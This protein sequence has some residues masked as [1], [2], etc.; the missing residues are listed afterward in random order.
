MRSEATLREVPVSGTGSP[1]RADEAGLFPKMTSVPHLFPEHENPHECSLLKEFR[2]VPTSMSGDS[3]SGRFRP[4]EGG[5]CVYDPWEQVAQDACVHRAEPSE[6]IVAVEQI[7][8]TPVEIR[9]G[10]GAFVAVPVDRA[11]RRSPTWTALRAGPQGRVGRTEAEAMLLLACAAG[12][13]AG[14]TRQQAAQ[15][16]A[17]AW[18]QEALGRAG[19]AVLIF[20][21]TEIAKCAQVS[22]T[23]L[24]RAA[25]RLGID[26]ATAGMNG[27]WVWA[28][29][30]AAAAT[31]APTID[32]REGDQVMIKGPADLAGEGRTS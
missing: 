28:L 2:D 17:D 15:R 31:P 22:S 11:R 24:R 4:S 12:M 6:L 23:A 30:V 3:V 32:S 27:G 18:L 29:P 1:G 10:R 9:E 14:G 25:S 21:L 8:G 16:A 7:V 13:V 5:P 20:E 26:G 19:G